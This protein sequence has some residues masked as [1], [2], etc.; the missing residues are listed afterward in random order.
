MLRLIQ[1]L[2]SLAI[3][4]VCYILFTDTLF[5]QNLKDIKSDTLFVNEF[6]LC[7][8]VVEREPIDVVQTFT[9]ENDRAWAYARIFNNKGI[10]TIT[11]RWI[12]N[13]QVYAEI[14]TRVGISGNWRTYS[15]VNIQAGSWKVTI[16]N[17]NGDVLAEI[18]FNVGE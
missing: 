7:K 18:R 9:V 13:D 12:F 8:D 17:S 15:N 4:S 1:F 16:I 10:E 14:D 5:A 6:L 11:F 3:V 2:K